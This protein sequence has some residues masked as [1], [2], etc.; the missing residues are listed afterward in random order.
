MSQKILHLKHLQCKGFWRTLWLAVCHL[1]ETIFTDCFHGS[2]NFLFTDDWIM[3]LQLPCSSSEE[4]DGEPETLLDLEDVG[5][6]LAAHKES[7][8]PRQMVTDTIR[9]NLEKQGYK[10]IGS[11]SGVKL[12]RWTKVGEYNSA[13]LKLLRWVSSLY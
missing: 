4:S 8:T 6:S 13:I 10:I 7:Q 12:C 2:T 11:H 5:V 1:Y 3:W 9:K